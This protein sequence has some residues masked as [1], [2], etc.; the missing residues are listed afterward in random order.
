MV[1]VSKNFYSHTN[2][3]CPNI[4]SREV[5]VH[6]TMEFYGGGNSMVVVW[7]LICL[8]RGCVST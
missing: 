6:T 7:Y 2:F 1:K 4:K 5:M 3:D 8:L